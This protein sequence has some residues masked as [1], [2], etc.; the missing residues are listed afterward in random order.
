MDVDKEV[1]RLERLMKDSQANMSEIINIY[2]NIVKEGT[3]TV[4]SAMPFLKD[5][6][7]RLLSPELME[8]LKK[9]RLDAFSYILVANS[10]LDVDDVKDELE[11]GNALTSHV[12]PNAIRK[13]KAELGVASVLPSATPAAER[14]SPTQLDNPQVLMSNTNDLDHITAS[15]T[16]QTRLPIEIKNECSSMKNVNGM[17]VYKLPLKESIFSGESS[18]IRRFSFG[19]PDPFGSRG[20]KTILLLGATGSGKTT[21]INAM[22]NYFL[23]VQWE[24]PFRFMLIDE[25]ETRNQA[26]SQTSEITAYDIHHRN[27]FRIPFSLTIVDTPGF[28]DTRGK[29]RD[30]EITSAIKKFFEHDNGIQE[31]ETVGF[32]VQSTLARLTA[33]QAHIFDSVLSIF[34]KDIKENVRFL[35]TFADGGQPSVL[36]AIKQAKLPCLLKS[37]GEP[38]HQVFN[39]RVMYVSNQA[40]GDQRSPLDWN[41]TMKNFQLFFTELCEMPIKSLKLTK[42][43]LQLR[44]IYRNRIQVLKTTIQA[45][46]M[47]MEELREIEKKIASNKDYVNANKDF[48]ITVKVAKEKQIELKTNEKALNCT[49]CKVTCHCPC[50]P[51]SWMPC[52]AFWTPVKDSAGAGIAIPAFALRTSLKVGRGLFEFIANNENRRRLA[53]KA[54]IGVGVAVSAEAA[55]TAVTAVAAGA[56]GT[57]VAAGAAGVAGAACC[58]AVVVTL[59]YGDKCQMCPGR[60]ARKHHSYE[61][62]KWEYVQE[63]ETRTFHDFRKKYDDAKEKTLNVEELK[64]ALQGEAAQLKSDIIE[65]MDKSRKCLNSLNEIALYGASPLSAP[66]YINLM[67]EHEKKNKKS[68]H[69]ERIKSLEDLKRTAELP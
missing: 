7:V 39:N 62:T 64:N 66:A 63:D 23:G 44:E 55:V 25:D 21:L 9:H 19:E 57:A 1:Q 38:C 12:P 32:V 17:S 22:V 45:R 13:L 68:G 29:K 37:N 52:P 4:S 3:S 65:V 36:A 60:C 53:A 14:A 50:Y 56:V 35:A 28:G 20:C 33:S 61:P 2:F 16:D 26:F 6:A 18:I 15:N 40:L 30:N 31:L 11:K 10:L 5:T 54:T 58:A 49:N 67:I 46:L 51:N 34:G 59:I 42:D 8:I 48:E 41:D 43:V 47:K 24:D 27:G 69:E